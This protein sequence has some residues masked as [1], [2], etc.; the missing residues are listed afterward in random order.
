MSPC[1]FCFFLMFGLY[2]KHYALPENTDELLWFCLYRLYSHSDFIGKSHRM[3]V[4]QAVFPFY[5]HSS[6]RIDNVTYLSVGIVD[7]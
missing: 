3:A 5:V 6:Y 4:Y 7:P 2:A 1:N